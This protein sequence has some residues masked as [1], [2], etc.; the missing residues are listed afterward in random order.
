VAE[1]PDLRNTILPKSLSVFAHSNP[2]YFLQ[3]GHKVRE[4]AS[5]DYLRK[6]VQGVL[7]W[8]GMNPP[9]LNEEDRRNAKQDAAL[10]L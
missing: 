5:L 2:V 8:L 6:Y 7:H 4:E 3:D 9:F 10:A 1:H